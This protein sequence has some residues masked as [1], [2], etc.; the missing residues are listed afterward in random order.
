[1]QKYY[2]A[3]PVEKKRI[4]NELRSNPPNT[5]GPPGPPYCYTDPS[6]R[7]WGGVSWSYFSISRSINAIHSFVRPKFKHKS[8]TRYLFFNASIIDCNFSEA[9]RIRHA[10]R[11]KN[12][13]T[14]LGTFWSIRVRQWASLEAI[15][16]QYHQFSLWKG[17][18]L[19]PLQQ[20]QV[21]PN[22]AWRINQS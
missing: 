5:P 19:Q 9:E 21:N 2:S 20:I 1:M 8:R 22:D 17:T 11:I 6:G 15:R 14:C 12:R 4:M 18:D 16:L 13:R 10:W 3:I 7:W